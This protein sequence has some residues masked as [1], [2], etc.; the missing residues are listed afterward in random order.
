[1]LSKRHIF[2][3][4]LQFLL[5]FRSHHLWFHPF[6][7]PDRQRYLLFKN[8]LYLIFLGRPSLSCSGFPL[9]Y[10]QLFPLFSDVLLCFFAS[11]ILYVLLFVCI[12]PPIFLLWPHH[13]QNLPCYSSYIIH[14]VVDSIIFILS[15]V[16][17]QSI[18]S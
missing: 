14:D 3:D 18:N 8:C 5:L 4:L 17:L 12:F 1:M 2:D 6:V 9:P 16:Y 13:P 10:I 11:F 15:Y 7:L